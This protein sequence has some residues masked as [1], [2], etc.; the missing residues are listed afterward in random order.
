MFSN[1]RG[2]AVVAVGDPH[3]Q[4]VV[5]APGSIEVAGD[6]DGSTVSLD[7]EVLLLITT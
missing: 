1:L 3:R 7:V 2:G 6:G 5:G 4:V